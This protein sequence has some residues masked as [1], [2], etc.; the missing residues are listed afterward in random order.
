MRL[1]IKQASKYTGY[2]PDTI[3]DKVKAH[4]IPH[5]LDD[6]KGYL[7]EEEDLKPFMKKSK[8]V[9][10]TQPETERSLQGTPFPHQAYTP[11]QVEMAKIDSNE[12]NLDKYLQTVNQLMAPIQK[13]LLPT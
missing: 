7:I 10:V 5:T 12:R 8:S 9:Q 4:I 11:E 3:R 1:S 13:I 6:K 2:S